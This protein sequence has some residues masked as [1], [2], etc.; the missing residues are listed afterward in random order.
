[1]DG[2]AKLAFEEKN[3]IECLTFAKANLNL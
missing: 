2:E 1:L 3:I